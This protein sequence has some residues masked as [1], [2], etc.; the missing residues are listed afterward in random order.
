MRAVVNKVSCNAVSLGLAVDI[1]PAAKMQRP[2]VVRIQLHD[3]PGRQI[4][5]TIPPSREL[6]D[7][8]ARASKKLHFDLDTVTSVLLH[9]SDN[10]A[11]SQIDFF[12]EATNCTTES[13]AWRSVLP[14]KIS[15][16]IIDAQ[17]SSETPQPTPTSPIS[18]ASRPSRT[19]RGSQSHRGPRRSVEELRTLSQQLMAQCR[20]RG[21][22][23]QLEL[24]IEGDE[25]SR[26]TER[27]NSRRGN[28]KSDKKRRRKGDHTAL[29]KLTT[30]L[31]SLL[32]DSEGEVSVCHNASSSSHT[33]SDTDV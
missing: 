21:I 4:S 29:M 2:D 31:Q 3:H 10:T 13:S 30:H 24:D 7:V 17:A 9:D 14:P 26:G 16:L 25:F 8:L 19:N 32:N 23:V 12:V 27:S 18:V 5:A 6:Y 15:L 11:T 33:E 28:T 1:S 20:A 22:V